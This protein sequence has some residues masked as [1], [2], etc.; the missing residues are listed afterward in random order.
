[1][2]ALPG[3]VIAGGGIESDTAQRF[4]GASTAAGVFHGLALFRHPADPR[5]QDAIFW[6]DLLTKVK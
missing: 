3:V 6:K 1:M 5:M 2:V 4:A